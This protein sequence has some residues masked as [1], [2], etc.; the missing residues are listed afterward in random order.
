MRSV[1]DWVW[2]RTP[3]NVSLEQHGVPPN[4][5]V[6][7]EIAGEFDPLSGAYETFIEGSGWVSVLPEEII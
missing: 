6:F 7:V 5:V 2:W 3:S 4:S 1:G